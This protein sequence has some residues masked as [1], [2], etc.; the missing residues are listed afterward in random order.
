MTPRKSSRATTREEGIENARASQNRCKRGAL[1]GTVIIAAA[2]VA[3]LTPSAHAA[4]G[5][6]P[7][8]ASL[9]RASAARILSGNPTDADIALIKNNPEFAK[10]IPDPTRTEISVEEAIIT[11]DGKAVDADGKPLT[12]AQLAEVMPPATA[13]PSDEAEEVVTPEETDVDPATSSASILRVSG[14]KW[15][16]THITHTH[17]S[18]SGHV[19]FKC[20]TYAE[21][22]YGSGKVRAWGTLPV[23]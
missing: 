18:Y 8:W 12:S 9:L 2:L 7:V 21:F 20:H 13:T 16:M 11:E 15:K 22:N 6:D 10:L 17:R 23:G 5:S 4:E 1:T 3:P 14:G 19:I